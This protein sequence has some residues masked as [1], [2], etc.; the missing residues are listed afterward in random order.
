M[1]IRENNPGDVI[2]REITYG[3][4]ADLI[5][6]DTRLEGREQQVTATSP[7]LNDTNRTL[8]GPVQFAW[9]KSTLSGR[10]CYL[11][12]YRQSSDGFA[13]ESWC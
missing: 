11:E 2:H 1:P 8:M 4:L 12:N 9:F 10:Y 3:N 7:L 5:M 6:V 13:F